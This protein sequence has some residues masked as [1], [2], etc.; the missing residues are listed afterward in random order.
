MLTKEVCDKWQE[1]VFRLKYL[2]VG[3]PYSNIVTFTCTENPTLNIVHG[4]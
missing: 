3:A 4:E 1:E 2:Y